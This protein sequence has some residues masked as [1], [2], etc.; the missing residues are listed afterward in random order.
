[1]RSVN[2]LCSSGLQAIADA[3]AAIRSGHCDIALAGVRFSPR[4]MFCVVYWLSVVLCGVSL[5]VCCV[6]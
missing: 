1:M 3:A 5:C 6:R 2:R 4:L